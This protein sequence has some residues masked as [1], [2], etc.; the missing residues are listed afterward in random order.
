MPL[1]SFANPVLLAFL[2]YSTQSELERMILQN[3][4]VIDEYLNFLL[5]REQTRQGLL[6]EPDTQLRI[7]RKLVRLFTE[8]DIKTASKEDIK[9]LILEYNRNILNTTLEKYLPAERPHIEQ[10]ADTLSNHAFLDKKDNKTIGFVNEFILGTL[11]AQNLISGKYVE[12]S[13]KFYKNLNVLFANLAF[14]AY[15]V[16]KDTEKNKLWNVF[17]SYPFNYESLF[18]LQIDIELKKSITRKYKQI[19]VDNYSI[20]NI[21]FTDTLLFQ[22]TIFTNCVFLNCTFDIGAFVNCS[23]VK[24]KFYDCKAKN[25]SQ[26][27]NYIGFFTSTDN[28]EFINNMEVNK[29]EISEEGEHEINIEKLILDKFFN[30][31]S[32]RP[33][34]RQF[35]QLSTELS[36]ISIKELNKQLHSL[37]VRSLVAMNG[38]L[39]HLTKDG[40][41][42]YN[43][44]YRKL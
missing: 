11:I 24:C 13:P 34:Y 16:Q 32:L 38:N 15:K 42:Y 27:N 18:Y 10:L 35:S 17:N 39:C 41:V 40:I 14:N 28:N 22:D 20:N 3:N 44:Q 4:T 23:F 31:G 43:E 2:K 21:L 7:F 8:L 29:L 6:I 19:A 9:E 26:S 36:D 30:Q 25:V 1:E 5:K 37:E 12:H 33:R